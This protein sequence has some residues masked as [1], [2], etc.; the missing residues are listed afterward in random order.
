VCQID[1]EW[2][3]L[4]DGTRLA[5]RIWMP[6]DATAD[7]VP[8]ILEAVPYRLSD[9]MATR[10][11][12]IHPWWAARGYACVRVDLRGSGESDGTLDD[13][14]APQEQEDLLEVI[15]WIARQPWCSGAVGMTGISWGG[16][17]SLQ[18]A[19]RRP[20]ALKTII[21]LM[22]TDDRYGDDVHY[23]GGCLMGTDLLH[24]SSC[25]LHWQCQPPHEVAVGERWRDLWRLR[26]ESNEPWIHTWLAHQ[27]RD[28]Y[29]KHGSVCED[30][31]AIEVPVYAIGGWAD[32]YTNAVLRLLDGLSGP[33]KG[34]IG[35]WGHGFPHYAAPGPAIGFLQESL[36]WWDHWL[37]GRD[38]GVMDEPM[39]RVWLQ[40]CALPSGRVSDRPGRWVAEDRW[41]SPRIEPRR[42]RLDA[43][44]VLRDAAGASRVDPEA[45]AAHGADDDGRL[46]IRGSQLCGIDA[47]AWCAEGQPSDAAPD[48]RA[49]E[50]Q[51]LCFTSAPLTDRLEILGHP[52]VELRCAADRPLALVA[53]RLDDVFHD[54]VSTLVA[55]QVFNLAHRDDH[56]HPGS[57]E[58]GREYTVTVRLD[59]IAHAFPAG[60]RLRVAISPT[61][62]PLA[63]PSPEP[64]ELTLSGGECRLELPARPARRADE[65]LPAFET[66]LIP[67]GLGE[68]TVGGGPGDRRYVRDLAADSVS[69]TYHYVDGGNVVMPN[70]W[71]SEEWNTVTYDVREGDPLSASVRVRVESV[72]RRGEQGR[73]RIVTLGRMTC[74]ASTFFVEDEVRVTEGEDREEREVFAKTWRRESPRDYV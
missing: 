41:P 61:Y 6:D 74:D 27:R 72:L 31:A 16:F 64:V 59:A 15:A 17:N 37:K 14:Y 2:I 9:G 13:E 68:Q 62:W 65:T 23:K 25:M 8:G 5:A 50:G 19:A 12:L 1:Y 73:F 10:D 34:L 30:Y 51:S 48:Q 44:G 70:G 49:A 55:Q 29:W 33:R 21:T 60:H 3:E 66:P 11:V 42:W 35:P 56:E 53:V 7:P 22:S 26:L 20:P 46:R 54:G 24:W 69:W 18:L 43:D 71:E 57:L 52:A 4:R 40:E 28:A 38:T 63:W 32:G 47:G 45:A 36:R 58:P 67:P 39:L